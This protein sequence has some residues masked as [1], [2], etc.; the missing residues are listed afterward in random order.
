MSFRSTTLL[1]HGREFEALAK[2]RMYGYNLNW[3]LVMTNDCLAN[4][5]RP[6]IHDKVIGTSIECEYDV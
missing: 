5:G 4:K 3:V 2:V 6:C 1:V